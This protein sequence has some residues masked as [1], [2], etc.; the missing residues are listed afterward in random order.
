MRAHS[1]RAGRRFV[2]AFHPRLEMAIMDNGADLKP[3][4]EIAAKAV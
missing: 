3:S 2:G 1:R 4:E